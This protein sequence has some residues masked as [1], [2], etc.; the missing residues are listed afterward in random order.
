MP[1]LL[2]KIIILLTL[3]QSITAF[4]TR[5]LKIFVYTKPGGAIDVFVR[6]FQSIAKNYTDQN[7]LVVNKPGA[8]GI[9]AMKHLIRQKDGHTIMAITKSNIGKLAGLR[10]GFSLKEFIWLSTLVVDPESL[11]INENGEINNWDKFVKARGR[12]LLWCGP[13]IGGN[14]HIMAIKIWEKMNIKGKWIP[15]SG[16]SK[17]MSALMG[18]HCDLYVGN[19]GDVI[20]KEGLVNMAIAAKE[21]MSAPFEKIPTFKELKIK[22]LE[23]EVM[24]RGFAGPK[25]MKK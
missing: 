7:I 10:K 8:G 23:Q 20:G 15:Y 19:P 2:V 22:G 16:G 1:K 11:I 21:R 5:D 14:D 9:I 24:W 4:P 6:K 25:R 12:E 3:A 13:A 17:A 18:K